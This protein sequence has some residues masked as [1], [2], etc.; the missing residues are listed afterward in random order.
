MISSANAVYDSQCEVKTTWHTTL[1]GPAKCV[2]VLRRPR[3]I[4]ITPF[5]DSDVYPS[6]HK[7]LPPILPQLPFAIQMTSRSSDQN[8]IGPKFGSALPGSTAIRPCLHRLVPPPSD[9]ACTI[10]C[11]RPQTRLVPSGSID[12]RPR[13]HHP[14]PPPSDQACTV[15]FHRPQTTLAPSGATALTQTTL[16]APD[17]TAL[18]PLL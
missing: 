10:R 8:S 11:H 6:N 13:L 18:R 15:W 9:H 1:R 17:S 12:L 3:K 4:V 16:A 7:R 2:V 14:V 5:S